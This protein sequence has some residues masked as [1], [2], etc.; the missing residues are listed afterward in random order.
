MKKVFF[1]I[2]AMACAGILGA[3]DTIY[4]FRIDYM[5]SVYPIMKDSTSRF[6]INRGE[7]P[8]YQRT[9]YGHSIIVP[10][11]SIVRGLNVA[12][13]LDWRSFRDS[14]E[15]RGVLAEVVNGDFNNPI[16]HFTHPLRAVSH[17]TYDLYWAFDHP[18][19]C[20]NS[21]ADTEYYVDTVLGVY[22]LY[23]DIPIQVR[24]TIYV[25]IYAT[26]NRP[27]EINPNY[28][29]WR[30][31]TTNVFSTGIV[32]CSHT[33]EL[34]CEVIWE[35][36]GNDMQLSLK[37]GPYPDSYTEAI[38]PIFTIPDTDSFGC[39]DVEGFAFAGINAGYPTFV[40]DTAGEHQLYEFAYGPYDAPM[41]SLHVATTVGG[42]FDLT[43][44][45]LSED[46]YYQAWLRAKCH[47]ACPLHDTVMWTPWSGPI[48]FYT[49]D[50]MP[51]T[52]HHQPR[53]EGIAE[54]QS[55]MA[56]TLTPNPAHGYV[57]LTVH[58]GEA[59]L[60]EGMQMTLHDA[61]GREVMRRTLH[62]RETRLSLAGLPAGL[63][64]V[65]V[66]PARRQT[67]GGNNRVP[68]EAHRLRLIVE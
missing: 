36:P 52:S 62:S 48:Y 12:A 33:D 15:I 31:I 68:A 19:L 45:R 57:T 1:L 30:F 56:F 6:T 41:D 29:S 9:V 4:P 59:G 44:E 34:S 23:F 5:D 14:V 32:D 58:G 27:S 64:T 2:M 50:S 55:G 67:A 51:D 37:R 47:H 13:F 42:I 49:G 61:A 21:I 3:Q 39:P 16:C 11:G 65:S 7:M 66:E 25:G 24:D 17:R 18:T 38:F 20:M 46:V 63:Y 35:D 8:Y 22:S 54:V 10:S 53:E 28:T 60:A 26:G 43:A 40:W